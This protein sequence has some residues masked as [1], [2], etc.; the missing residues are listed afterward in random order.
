MCWRESIGKFT[1]TGL[2]RIDRFVRRRRARRNAQHTGLMQPFRTYIARPLH[3][4]H[5][6]AKL[7]AGLRQL[8]RVIAVHTAND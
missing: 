6:T 8:R 1:Y 3:V 7:P 4:M 2:H 5:R